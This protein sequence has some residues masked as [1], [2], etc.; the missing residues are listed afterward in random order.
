MNRIHASGAAPMKGLAAAKPSSAIRQ[1]MLVG[2]RSMLKGELLMFEGEMLMFDR[3]HKGLERQL[4]MFEAATF[5]R[6]NETF[7]RSAATFLRSDE[8][9]LRSDAMFHRATETKGLGAQQRPRQ[10]ARFLRG[11]AV[12]AARPAETIAEHHNKT[13]SQQWTAA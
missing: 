4:L 7:L 11:D 6:S 9:F 8:T 5:L 3:Q 1:S 2:E 13:V 10:P 12:P